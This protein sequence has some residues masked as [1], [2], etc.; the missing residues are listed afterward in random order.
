MSQDYTFTNRTT[1]HQA[2]VWYDRHWGSW[3]VKA[4]DTLPPMPPQFCDCE[5]E[6]IDRAR[7]LTAG[8]TAL[9][10]AAE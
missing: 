4:L 7:E 1:G 6:A 3:R 10:E 9:L 2:R 8:G 5:R